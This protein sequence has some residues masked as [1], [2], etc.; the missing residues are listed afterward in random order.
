MIGPGPA[1]YTSGGSVAFVGLVKFTAT[2]RTFLD[3]DA[4]VF[5]MAVALAFDAS[6][7]YAD[8]FP[9][10]NEVVVNTNASCEESIGCVRVRTSYFECGCG[11]PRRSFVG[12]LT[13]GC[14][15]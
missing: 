1:G 5:C 7:W 13:P 3:T 2:D 15:Y 12:A 6:Y 14:C 8:V 9:D 10:S 11:L 4:R